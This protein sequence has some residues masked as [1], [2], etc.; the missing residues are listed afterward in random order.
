MDN[1]SPTNKL[2]F[3][4]FAETWNGRLAMIGFVSAMAVE[5]ATGKGLLAQLGIM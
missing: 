3:T 4:E 5:F 2:G 1:N